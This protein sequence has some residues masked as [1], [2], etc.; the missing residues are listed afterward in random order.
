MNSHDREAI[1][2]GRE[3]LTKARWTRLGQRTSACEE[4]SV[5]R[6]ERDKNKLICGHECTVKGGGG[7]SRHEKK[8]VYNLEKIDDVVGQKKIRFKLS[9]ESLKTLMMH[10]DR[11]A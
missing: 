7:G 1:K 9:W 4:N 5:S 2:R 11:Y 8:C 10:A 3:K 6:R